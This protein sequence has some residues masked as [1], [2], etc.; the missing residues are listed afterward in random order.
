MGSIENIVLSHGHWDHSGAMLRA[1]QMI[2]L[3]NGS[4]SV[5]TYLHPGVHRLRAVKGQDGSMHPMDDVP[6]SEQLERHGAFVVHTAE[7]QL[8]LDNLFFL[9]GEIPRVTAFETGM[10]SHYGRTADGTDWEPDPL[11]MD[12]RFVAVSVK[13]KGVIVFTACS[14]A[15]V[16]NVLTHARD[17][18]PNQRLH[19]VLGGFHLAGANERIIPDTVGALRAF[20]L[21][22][23]AAAH[24]TGWR[25]VSAMSTVFG[26][27]VVPSAVGKTYRF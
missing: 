24:C 12:E 1:L 23:I 9:S 7:P 15:D 16:I 18:F 10:P 4:R 25:A 17:C 3:R 13:G 5:P 14:H 2:Q 22:T 6:S 26:E 8:L 21:T 19:G 11:I 20:N 27:A